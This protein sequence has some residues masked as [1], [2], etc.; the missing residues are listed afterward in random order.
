MNS[1]STAQKSPITALFPGYPFVQAGI[2]GVAAAAQIATIARS[3]F[4]PGGTNPGNPDSLGAGGGG[5]A[6]VP[7][8]AAPPDLEFQEQQAT[9]IGQSD[10]GQE[11]LKAYVIA[12]EVT[13]AQQANAEIEN[14]ATL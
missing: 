1:F 13:N 2:A 10:E 11:P 14:L 8:N 3:K 6:S 12:G 4:Q 9:A 5:A 7:N